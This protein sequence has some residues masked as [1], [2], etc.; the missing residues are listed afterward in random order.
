MFL[1]SSAKPIDPDLKN[2]VDLTSCTCPI[3]RQGLNSL[4]CRDAIDR[5]STLKWTKH[6]FTVLFRGLGLLACDFNRK[7]VR[8]VVQSL[9]RFC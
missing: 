7:R 1:A 8:C 2:L 3:F 6:F 9:W 4:A 5:V